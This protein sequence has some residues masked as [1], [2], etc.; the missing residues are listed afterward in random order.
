VTTHNKLYSIVIPTRE[1]ADVLKFSI[2]TVLNQTARNFEIVVMDNCGSPATKEVV[3][4]FNSPHIRYIRSDERLAMSANWEIA[5]AHANGDYIGFLGDDDGLFPD[6]IEIAS[7]YHRQWPDAMFG[8]KALTWMWPEY[9]VEHYSNSAF[10]HFGSHV[11]IHHAREMLKEVLCFRRLF[12][13]APSLYCSFVPKF[14]IDRVRTVTNQYFCAALPDIYSIVANL[15]ASETVL[16]SWRPLS[17]WGA[18]HHSTG[19]SMWFDVGGSKDTF[20]SEQRGGKAEAL[21]SGLE[22]EFL[23]EVLIANTYLKAKD[24][25]FPKDGELRFD[26]ELFLS[27]V[28][29]TAGRL[30][31]RISDVQAAVNRMAANWGLDANRFVVTRFGMEKP[32]AMTYR[33][34]PEDNIAHFTFFTDPMHIKTISDF[35]S[36][37]MR[38][39]VPPTQIRVKDRRVSG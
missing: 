3:D 28:C 18:S 6:A 35:V 36:S 8:W 5:L 19:S 11:E 21:A 24:N 29:S 10:M 38:M 13:E 23:V 34:Q 25:L 2:P 16:Y 26:P 7:R 1:R 31:S 39:V 30:A 17:V 20:V 22:G 15:W 27:S 9:I 4:S 32:P 33:L 14:A 12:S 37:A